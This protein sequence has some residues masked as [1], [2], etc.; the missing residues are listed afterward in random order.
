MFTLRSSAFDH[1]SAIPERH[2]C[3]GDDLSPPLA[4]SGAPAGTVCFALIVDDPDAP[5]PAA[6]K[7]TWVHWIRYDI[8]ADRASLPEGAGNGP[9]G[10][11]ERDALNDSNTFG[12]KGPCPPIGRHRYF[13]RLFALSKP[14]QDLGTS[15]RRADLERVMEGLVLG[16]AVL[17]GT[18][19]RTP[20]PVG[21]T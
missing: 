9:P 20:K 16:T 12:W 6:P 10:K 5:D 18:Y 2:T 7:R 4:W 3:D 14:I 1:E 13:F 15:A 17:M 8:A 19:A 21:R 11:G